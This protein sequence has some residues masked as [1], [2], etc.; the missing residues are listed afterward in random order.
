MA[1]KIIESIIVNYEDFVDMDFNPPSKYYIRN[2]NGDYEFL[3]GNKREVV[4]EFFDDKYGVGK[5]S[6]RSV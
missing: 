1:K 5:F 2:P 4:Q 6:V 3:K